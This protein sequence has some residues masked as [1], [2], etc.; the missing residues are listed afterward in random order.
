ML[1]KRVISNW[2]KM[3]FIYR[4]PC[5]PWLVGMSRSLTFWPRISPA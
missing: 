2:I 3:H 5:S 4:R 1:S